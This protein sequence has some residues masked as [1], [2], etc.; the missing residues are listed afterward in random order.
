[1][2]AKYANLPDIVSM[3]CVY[4]YSTDPLSVRT[5]LQTSMRRMMSFPPRMRVCVMLQCLQ[6]YHSCRKS[7]KGDSSD[8]D[9][10][11]T[12]RPVARGKTGE[13]PGREELDGTHLSPEEAS[14][15]FRKA[16]KSMWHAVFDLLL[17]YLR[18][19]RASSSANTVRLS[20]IPDFRHIAP[21]NALRHSSAPIIA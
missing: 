7:Q 2:S 9:V 3:C 6:T 12:S 11:I 4:R 13:A 8:D 19:C 10:G 17:I 18:L 1:M 14:R 20:P 5:Q 21:V 15:K 16:E